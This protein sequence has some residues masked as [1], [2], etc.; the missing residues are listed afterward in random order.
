MGNTTGTVRRRR[1]QGGVVPIGRGVG[2]FQ[3][4]AAASSPDRIQRD[5]RRYVGRLRN[6]NSRRF[7]SAV[8]RWLSRG[9]R[10]PEPD[11]QDYD[12]SERRASAIATRIV[13]IT[14]GT[15]RA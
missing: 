2:R 4:G 1:R 7:A 13:S 10:G 9:A 3:R 11:P 14:R 5:I 15:G 8:A 6:D 12:L